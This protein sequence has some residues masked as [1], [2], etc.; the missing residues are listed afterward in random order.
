MAEDVEVSLRLKEI[1]GGRI[2]YIP[3]MLVLNKVYPYRLTNKYILERSVWIGHSRRYLKNE[4][5][6]GLVQENTL[7]RGLLT[8][9]LTASYFKGIESFNTLLKLSRILALSIP[10]V[11]L[12]YLFDI[13][14]F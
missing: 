2:L 8:G 14:K 10:T 11:A 5:H 6:K 13:R 9:L 12:G 1:S 4:V 3:D 7:L